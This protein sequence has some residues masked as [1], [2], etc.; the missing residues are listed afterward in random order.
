MPPV[1]S[2]TVSVFG[3]GPGGLMAA[4]VLAAGGAH[5][6]VYEHMR[7]PGRKFTLAG[8]GGLNLT[9]SEA[10]DEFAQRYSGPAARNVVSA[11]RSFPPEELENWCA[12]LGEPT[13]VGSSGRVFPASFRATPLLRAWLTRLSSLGVTV[14]TGARWLGWAPATA[15]STG[16]RSSLVASDDGTVSEVAADA[17]VVALG[18]ASWPRVGSD[19]G[20]VEPFRSAGVAVRDLRPSNCGMQIEWTPRFLDRFSGTPVKNVAVRVGAQG[21]WVRGD[22]M[23]VDAGIEGGPVYAH[24]G[25]ARDW[26]ERTGRCD[27]LV[28]LQPDLDRDALANRLA[29]RREKDSLDNVLRRTVGL[30]PVARA[31]IREA[32]GPE[33]PRDDAGLANAIKGVPFT[34]TATT[35]IDRAISSAGGIDANEVDESFMLRRVPGCFVAGEMLDWEAPTGGYLLQATF[36]TAVAAARG[37]L[38]W[39]AEQPPAARHD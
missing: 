27:L 34:V 11:V 10:L 12:A 8:R 19:G 7:S 18:G 16:A 28:D 4:E 35:G 22:V 30:A 38:E 17:T 3:G 32:F 37:A 31:L 23:V 9:H 2:A 26:I 25:P 5:V 15:G 20:W 39:L 21:H 6:T 14:Q 13:F 1:R 29:R 36:S 24:A 33:V